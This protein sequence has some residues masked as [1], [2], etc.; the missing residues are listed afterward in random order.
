MKF[1]IVSFVLS[2]LMIDTVAI[3][4]P[5][6]VHTITFHPTTVSSST[7]ST[8][9]SVFTSTFLPFWTTARS[10]WISGTSTGATLRRIFLCVLVGLLLGKVIQ[11][12]FRSKK[13]KLPQKTDD[14]KT[15][16]NKMC[17]T[18][19]NI[20]REEPPPKYADIHHV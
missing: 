11:L 16:E 7:D 14:S 13:A 12:I 6:T 8:R 5:R 1:L 15:L 4:T 17:V 10:D 20:Q 2:Y 18:T 9:S 19:I 3:I